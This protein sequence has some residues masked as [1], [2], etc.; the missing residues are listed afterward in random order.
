MSVL[1]LIGSPPARAGGDAFP[2][3]ARSW[4][5]ANAVVA[6][7]DRY[8][9]VNN[10]AGLAGVREASLFSSY[11]TYYGFDGLGTVAFGAVI[12]VN[13]AFTTGLSVQRFGDKLYNQLAFGLGAGHRINRISLGLKVSYV[14]VAVSAPSLALSRKAFLVEMGGI[15]QLTSKVNFGAH[16]YNVVQGGFAGESEERLPTVL[17][18][19]LNYKPLAGLNL[20][21]ELVKDTAQPTSFRAGI[22]YQPLPSLFL[23]TGIA[24]HPQTNHFG[25]GFVGESFQVD[26]AVHTHPQLGWSHHFTVAYSF[27]KKT[28]AD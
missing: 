15:V 6:Q 24:T 20:S 7:S 16:M 14:Q 9:V 19:G 22:E 18:A 5:L 13:D 12:P 4:G 11:H 25:V 10:I 3:G 26:Y 21:G 23:R 17:R 1:L 8:S 28:K 27:V 2:I